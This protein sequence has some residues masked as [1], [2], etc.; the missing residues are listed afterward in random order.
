V[1]LP[2][3]EAATEAYEREIRSEFAPAVGEWP[4]FDLVLLGLGP[5][6]HVASLF[7]GSEAL[8]ERRRMVAAP[9]VEALHARRYT[10]TLPVINAAACVLFLVSGEAKAPILRAVLQGSAGAERCPAQ[11]VHPDRGTVLWLMDR[12]AAGRLS[13]HS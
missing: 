1:G 10:L 13:H 4:R 11:R 9:W 3:P 12:A 2:D 5:D 6:G 7:P 8:E